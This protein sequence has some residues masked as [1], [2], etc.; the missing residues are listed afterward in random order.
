MH[1]DATPKKTPTEDASPTAGH[2]N[3]QTEPN[4]ATTD[5]VFH[6]LIAAYAVQGHGLRRTGPNDGTVTSWVEPWGLVRYLPDIDR[7]RQFL[8]QIGGGRL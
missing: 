5:K 3:S 8:E 1:T 7:T 2:T 4:P 6:S